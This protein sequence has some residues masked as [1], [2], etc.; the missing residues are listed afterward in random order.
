MQGSQE[1]FFLG[2]NIC[3][4]V[5]HAQGSL[6]TEEDCQNDKG[7]KTAFLQTSPGEQV[8]EW[9]KN[10]ALTL[11]FC[12]LQEKQNKNITVAEVLGDFQV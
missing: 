1:H 8:C 12:I 4:F 9:P 5:V 3:S 2:E 7:H 6:V 10:Y 11:H